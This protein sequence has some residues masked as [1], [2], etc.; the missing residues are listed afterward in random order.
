MTIEGESKD[1]KI[2]YMTLIERLQKYQFYHHA[3]LISICI[4]LVKKYY[5]LINSK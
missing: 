1:E 5:L 3:K 2:Q 4:L